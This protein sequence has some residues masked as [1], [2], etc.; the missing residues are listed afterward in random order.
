[1]KKATCFAALLG[2]GLA[3]APCGFAQAPEA[4]PAEATAVP[5]IPPDQQ[6]TT[7]QLAKLFELMRFKQQMATM[8]KMMPTLMQQQ[9]SAQIKQMQKDHPEKA[10]M[11]EEQQQASAKV[12]GKFMERAMSIN[13]SDELIAD[14]SALYQKHLSRSDVDGII[15]FYSSP[16][17][18]HMLDR[19]PVIMSEFMPTVMKRV[20][21]RMKPIVEEMT[22]EMEAITKTSA[23]APAADKPAQK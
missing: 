4:A 17:G 12:M 15:A 23:P 18:Q 11:T 21:E 1:M 9:F 20:Q 3:L 22:K 14:M 7:E 6:P 19:T 8:T 2:M 13:T 16:A 10:P 5:A